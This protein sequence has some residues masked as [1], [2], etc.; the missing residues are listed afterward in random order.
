MIIALIACVL[1]I[2][3]ND[4]TYKHSMI[5]IRCVSNYVD[6]LRK[7]NELDMCTNYYDKFEYNYNEY[8]FNLKL[9]GRY[10]YIKPEY[11]E[12]LKKYDRR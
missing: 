12:M 10:S 6:D 4:Y 7:R 9:W 5:A 2:F 3:R 1:F 11:R 8:M